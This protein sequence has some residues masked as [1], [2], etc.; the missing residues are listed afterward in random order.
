MWKRMRRVYEACKKKDFYT[1][2]ILSSHNGWI[3]SS[4]YGK[5]GDISAIVLKR[6]KALLSSVRII[7]S[8]TG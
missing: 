2:I 3:E 1:N 6:L 5:W 4:A 8:V 7:E